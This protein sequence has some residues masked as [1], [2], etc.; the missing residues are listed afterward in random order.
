[1]STTTEALPVHPL[2][3]L[4]PEMGADEFAALVA[5]VRSSGLLEPITTFEGQVLDGRHR[6]R[7]C[8]D[9]GVD[10]RFVEYAGDSPVAFVIDKN[11][12]RRQLTP[13]Q[14]AMV[15]A[16]ALPQLEDEARKRQGSRTDLATSSPRGEE[17]PPSTLASEEAARLTGSS[18]RS[19]QRAKRITEAAADPG[20]SDEERAE[21]VEI[22]RKVRSGDL[23][24]KPAEQQISRAAPSAEPEQTRDPAATPE[25]K[26]ER[27]RVLANAAAKRFRD[28]LL[29]WAWGAEQ[30]VQGDLRFDITLVAQAMNDDERHEAAR[31]LGKGAAAFRALAKQLTEESR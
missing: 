8:A 27:H 28:S 29:Q 30:A 6:Q 7:A 16:D 22:E 17:V 26:N 15:A 19:V 11:V 3:L 18:P 25:F 14:R 23:A 31:Q 24:L 21:A 9:A 20:R 12:N 4:I 2:A 5:S 1:V 10:P 13:A